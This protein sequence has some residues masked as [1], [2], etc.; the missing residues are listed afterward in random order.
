[1][2]PNL[3]A[4]TAG[5]RIGRQRRKLSGAPYLAFESAAGG[6]LSGRPVR[7]A[8]SVVRGFTADGF[9]SRLSARCDS[10]SRSAVCALTERLLYTSPAPD[11]LARGQHF[12]LTQDGWRASPLPDSGSTG[13]VPAPNRGR[14]AGPRRADRAGVGHLAWPVHLHHLLIGLGIPGR[15]R[16]RQGGLGMAPPVPVVGR[17]QC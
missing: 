2:P 9:G 15:S 12:G 1:M 11:L 16:G 3:G 17:R 4:L 7:L 13:L 6:Q 8:A 14:S 10:K 5:R